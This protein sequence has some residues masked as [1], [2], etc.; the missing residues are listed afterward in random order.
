MQ[1]TSPC[2]APLD[3]REAAAIL[4]F[5]EHKGLPTNHGFVFSKQQI[6]LYRARSMRHYDTR[7]SECV[8]FDILPITLDWNKFTRGQVHRRGEFRC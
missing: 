5:H 7:N 4:E 6:E 3:L 2:R 1:P 8:Q